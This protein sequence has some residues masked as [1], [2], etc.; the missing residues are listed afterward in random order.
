MSHKEALFFYPDRLRQTLPRGTST[1]MNASN[2]PISPAAALDPSILFSAAYTRLLA[3]EMELDA[4][5]WERLLEGTPLTLEKLSASDCFISLAHQQR[6]IHNALAMTDQPGLGLRV[7]SKLHLIA[8]GPVGVAA[9]SAPSLAAGFDVMVRFHTTR[10]QF[11]TLANRRSDAGLHVRLIPNVALDPVGLFLIE[12]LMA[13]F[14]CS[15]DFVMGRPMENLYFQFEYPAPPHAGMYH[16]LLSHDCHFGAPHTE[17]LLP[18]H[19]LQQRSLF[20]DEELHR[21]AINQCLLIEQDLK[22]HQRLSDQI[23]KRIRQNRYNCSLEDM[24]GQFNVSPRTL[25]RKL[26]QEDASFSVI[27]EQELQI[28]AQDYLR[29]P[30]YSIEA[31]AEMLGY[32]NVVNFRRAFQRWFGM[33]PGEF[34][35][36]IV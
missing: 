25:I 16:R 15:M 8:H 11:V 24:A 27:M 13:S 19:L 6:I 32:Q 3:H 4:Q 30:Q 2:N 34:R 21:Q 36:Q 14:R 10:A 12:A 29:N 9:S 20:A 28:A 7:G 18:E 26:K 31:I 1:A 23:R 35:R 33:P 17:I 5:G 22:S